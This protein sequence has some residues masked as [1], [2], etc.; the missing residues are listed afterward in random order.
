MFEDTSQ[1]VTIIGSVILGGGTAF[2]IAQ[3]LIF[4][5]SIFLSVIG[6][7]KEKRFSRKYMFVWLKSLVGILA[8]ALVTVM[9]FV[10]GEE[11]KFNYQDVNYVIFGCAAAL[12]ILGFMFHVS[13]KIRRTMDVVSTPEFDDFHVSVD[14][15]VEDYVKKNLEL[16]RTLREG[17]K[18]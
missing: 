16:L 3:V 14:K 17:S 9:A 10:I 7:M 5:G 13:K 2:I 8:C 12:V 1:L 15:G 18:E 4:L 6:L 11:L